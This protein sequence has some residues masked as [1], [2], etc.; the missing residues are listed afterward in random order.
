MAT[1]NDA[2]AALTTLREYLSQVES[3]YLAIDSGWNLEPES[4]DGMA[5]RV[6]S[7]LLANLDEQLQAAY[8]SVDPST[9]VGVQLDRIARISGISRQIATFSTATVVFSGSDGVVIPSGTE[10]RNVETDTT[11]ATDTTAE[12]SSGEA[13]VN[14]TCTAAGSEPAAAGDLSEIVNPIGGVS[15][16]TN[17]DAASLGRDRETDAAFRARRRASVG[18]PGKNQI[19]STFG[20]TAN[21]DGVNNARIYEN[22][23]NSADGNGL[24]PHS[25]A[26]FVDGGDAVA[27]AEAI[28]NTKA[29]G[30]GLNENNSYPNKVQES[31]TTDQ[32]NPLTVTFFRPELV[33]A[34]VEV[35]IDGAISTSTMDAIK[36]AIIE[37]ASADYFGEAVSGFDKTGF[38]IGAIAKAS[39]LYTPV[40]R[41]I[42]ESAAVD[43]ILLGTSAGSI[44]QSQ[45]DPGFNGLTVFEESA[46]SVVVN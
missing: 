19:D 37:Y 41:V 1:I 16:V 21:V 27:V 28:A 26:I 9:A 3:A 29:P 23:T 38:G 25:M 31:V 15:G 12:I 5:I 20:R 2:G 4:P 34:Y 22:R 40:N 42:G 11:W 17:P 32:G 13:T 45:I 10:V 14:V 39:K 44:N 36:A 24:D 33:T 7:E 8:A 18:A 6:W 35:Q 43:S 46:I 30:C